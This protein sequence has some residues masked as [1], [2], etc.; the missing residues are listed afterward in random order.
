MDCVFFPLLLSRAVTWTFPYFCQPSPIGGTLAA[1]VADVAARQV[2]VFMMSSTGSRIIS[3]H[4]P[5]QSPK[6]PKLWL[7]MGI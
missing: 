5:Y 7:F 1:S 2:C 6:D 3:W 4:N